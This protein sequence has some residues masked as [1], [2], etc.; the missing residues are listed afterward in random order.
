MR[1]TQTGSLKI[2]FSILLFCNSSAKS[3]MPGDLLSGK[4]SYFKFAIDYLSNAVYYGRK[5]SFALPYITPAISYHDKSGLYIEGSLSYL[6]GTG[7]Q[8]D[9]GSLT[10]GYEFSSLNEKISGD[11]YASKFFVN[12]SSYSVRGEVNAATGGSLYYNTGPLTL[13]SGLDV[14]FSSKTDIALNFGLSHLFE[15]GDGHWSLTPSAIVNAGTQNFYQNYLTNR[16]YSLKRKRR[17]IQNSGTIKVIVINKSFSVLDYELSVPLNYASHKWGLFF[18]P[19]FS[20]PESTIKY[21]LNNGATYR[22]ENLSNTFYVEIGGYI[23]F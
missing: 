16:K 3:Q 19:T 12:N 14:S 10:A 9:A 15:F 2:I 4:E 8:V 17:I 11:V 23:K 18:T 13:N 22:T 20:I 5:D 1:L 6:A 21:S 7:S